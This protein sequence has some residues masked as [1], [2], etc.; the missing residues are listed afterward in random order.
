MAEVVL[1]AEKRVEMVAELEALEK[2]P[3]QHH[4]AD[5]LLRRKAL[6]QE[7]VDTR[8]AVRRLLTLFAAGSA[9]ILERNQL[10]MAE[11]DV[12]EELLD[13]EY[14]SFC[15]YVDELVNSPDWAALYSTFTAE[16]A[17]AGGGDAAR[18]R[19]LS[20]ADAALVAMVVAFSKSA[21][22]PAAVFRAGLECLRRLKGLVG[23]MCESQSPE[24]VEKLTQAAA[25]IGEEVDAL[26]VMLLTQRERL[27]GWDAEPLDDPDMEK[28]F[29]HKLRLAE[30][31]ITLEAPPLTEDW[32]AHVNG[33]LRQF[34]KKH[35]RIFDMDAGS[36]CSGC[37]HI[38]ED[39]G[40][41]ATRQR[42]LQE[43]KGLRNQMCD[44]ASRLASF[45]GYTF[46]MGGATAPGGMRQRCTPRTLAEAGFFY[47]PISGSPDGVACY[48][49]GVW[50]SGWQA[51]DDP[52]ETH[53]TIDKNQMNCCA[54]LQRGDIESALDVG[55]EACLAAETPD[56]DLLSP[57]GLL[58]P[59][60]VF[61]ERKM[62][63][64]F[65]SLL[66][67]PEDTTVSLTQCREVWQRFDGCGLPQGQREVAKA[68]EAFEHKHD[69]TFDE[70]TLLL[71]QRAK[72]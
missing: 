26:E 63:A 41:P 58:R 1:L 32:L 72:V 65:N 28:A 64:I 67:G 22:Y 47:A 52:M 36:N 13:P 66:E 69:L 8:E 59:S 19:A 31:L 54:F 57:T 53:R 70:F 23:S 27:S 62:R 15:T 48:S 2:A 61:D 9:Q 18:C 14:K 35:A 37:E 5:Q 43:I 16:A 40:D 33:I 55:V 7:E 20:E 46:F 38:D 6:A 3:P 34:V 25:L 10:A 24:G 42:E 60:V 17:V 49:C 29:A 44:L 56:A 51:E 68:F 11:D 21:V 45:K 4:E 50:L 12:A 71:L 39:V 30:Q